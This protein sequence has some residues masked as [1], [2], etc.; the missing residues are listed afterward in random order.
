MSASSIPAPPAAMPLDAQWHDDF[1]HA[2]YAFL[3]GERE[4]FLM[5]F[6]VLADLAKSIRDGFVF[7][8]KYS[9]Y[10]QRHYGSSSKDRPGEQ[11]VGFIQNHDQVANTSRGKRL[12][13]LVSRRT[14]EAGGS[15]DSLLALSC[16]CCSWERSTER[17]R[18]S[19]SSPASKIPI[20][21]PPCSEGRKRELGSHYSES[22]FADPHALSY[23]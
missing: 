1:H 4:G 11:F 9:R 14:A 8:W 15:A 10:R 5:D 20:W 17:L 6:G 16:R 12:S 2:L 7:D 19:F 21:L 18:R 13:S 3:T 23:F 22:D